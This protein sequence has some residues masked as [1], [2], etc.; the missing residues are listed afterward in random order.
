[1]LIVFS[2]SLNL[3]SRLWQAIIFREALIS[4]FQE[5]KMKKSV[6]FRENVSTKFDFHKPL[7]Q[8]NELSTCTCYF[9]QEL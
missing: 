5:D 4:R 1:M 8:S 3:I 7:F 2:L 6:K 9:K